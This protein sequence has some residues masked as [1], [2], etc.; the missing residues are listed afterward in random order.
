M[1]LLEVCVD[2]VESA[3]AAEK[4]GADR[5]ELCASLMTGGITPPMS[6]FHAVKKAVQIPIHVLMRP[7]FGDFCYTPYEFDMLREDVQTFRR[8]GA[9]GAVIGILTEDGALD[10]ARMEALMGDAQGM[11]VTLHRAFDVCADPFETLETARRLGVGTIL[12]S[13]QKNTCLEGR[14]LL[15]DLTRRAGKVEILA[16]GGVNADVIAMLTP[17]VKSFHMSGK[18]TLDSPMKFRREGVSMG[19]PLMSEYAV[20]RT[21]HDEIA[22]ARGVLD[23]L[24]RD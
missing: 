14:A 8:E 22:R 19:L 24:E 16:G 3:I 17:D 6:L 23:G 2:S 4:G 20:W 7:R 18:K 12:T 13:G 1:Y 11:R 10:A 21:D 15:T 9:A 5:L